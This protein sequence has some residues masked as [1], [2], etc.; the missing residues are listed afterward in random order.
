MRQPKNKINND[1]AYIMF[2][3]HSSTSASMKSITAILL[4]DEINH[5]PQIDDNSRIPAFEDN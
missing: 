4:A 3:Y 1:Y 5:R 2:N